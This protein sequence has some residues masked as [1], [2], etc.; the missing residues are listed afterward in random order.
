MAKVL[1]NVDLITV[2]DDISKQALLDLNIKTPIYVTA[3]AVLSMHPVDSSI[4][5]RLLS[6]YD[7]KKVCAPR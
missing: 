7:L 3:D 5:K 6:Q 2:R 1:N 4:G